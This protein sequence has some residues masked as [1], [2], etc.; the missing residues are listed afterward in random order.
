M[1]R[2]KKLKLPK[3]SIFT[4]GEA[5]AAG[6]TVY[7]L[8]QLIA[9][10]TIEKVNRGVYRVSSAEVSEEESYK[11]ASLRIGFPSAICVLTALS[12][13]QLT[14][15]IPKKAWLLVDASKR[16]GHR[17]IRLLRA[18][19]AHWKVGI[20]KRGGYW[21]T[22]LERTL[23]ESVIYRRFIGSNVAMEAVRRA[24]R[25]EK[26]T[27]GDLMDMAKQLGVRDRLRPYIEALA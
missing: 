24:V 23:V 12:H 8:R 3:K 1:A 15:A 13:Y 25:E 10:G 6:L 22:S 20:E 2:Y 14:D 21:L 11:A 18:R 9:R 7:G 16:T 17:D 4:R 5:L 26:T 19:N 27:L